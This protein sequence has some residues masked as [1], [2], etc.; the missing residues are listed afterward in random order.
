M[1]KTRQTNRSARDETAF[2]GE[3]Q[4]FT[5]PPGGAPLDDPEA[6]SGKRRGRPGGRRKAATSDKQGKL[7]VE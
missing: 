6:R 3:L 1:H 4:K 5:D 2:I 7:P